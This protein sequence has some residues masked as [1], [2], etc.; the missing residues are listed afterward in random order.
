MQARRR[1][2]RD[3]SRHRGRAALPPGQARGAPA[4]A[5]AERS[6]RGTDC[7]P[8][9]AG[10]CQW[11]RRAAAGPGLRPGGF[12]PARPRQARPGSDRGTESRASQCLRVRAVAASR[13]TVTV[14]V[15]VTAAAQA[16]AR[17]VPSLRLSGTRLPGPA[18]RDGVPVAAVAPAGAGGLPAG[19]AWRLPAGGPPGLRPD[20]GG[21]IS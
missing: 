4:P 12:G 11:L 15:T 3:E 8:G 7:R 13:V 16:E 1:L 19:P 2:L 6:L 9:R 5:P 20:P 10:I 14:T 17:S 21:L 18:A